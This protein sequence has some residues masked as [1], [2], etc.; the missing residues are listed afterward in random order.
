LSQLR[1]GVLLHTGQVISNTRHAMKSYLARFSPFLE[2]PRASRV[3]TFD[4]WGISGS[5]IDERKSEQRLLRIKITQNVAT[6]FRRADLLRPSSLGQ[7]ILR[8]SRPLNSASKIHSVT[9]VL[10]SSLNKDRHHLFSNDKRRGR[11]AMSDFLQNERTEEN[12]DGIG[13]IPL[14]RKS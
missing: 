6:A 4:R 11:P 7:D 2:P 8:K 13:L 1:S 12:S 14:S 5:H 9:R 10:R 3:A